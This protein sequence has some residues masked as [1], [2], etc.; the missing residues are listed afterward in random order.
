MSDAYYY[1]GLTIEFDLPSR[2]LTIEGRQIDD[3]ELASLFDLAAPPDTKGLMIRRFAEDKIEN[4]PSLKIRNAAQMSQIAILKE[5]VA[6]WNDWR[7]AHPEVRPLLYGSNLTQAALGVALDGVDFAN[8]VLIGADLRGQRMRRANFHEANLGAA[9]LHGADLTEGN[10]C[11]AD[12]YETTLVQAILTNANLQGA[13]LAKTNLDGAHLVGCKVYGMAAW[14]LKL[15]SNT[16]QRDLSIRYR[17]AG[18]PDSAEQEVKV[19]DV[20]LAQAV[21]LVLNNTKLTS[22]INAMTSRAVLI[23]GRFSADRKLVLDAIRAELRRLN[24]VPMLF[25]FQGPETRDLIETVGTLAHLAR[26]VIADITDARS[27][28]QELQRIVPNLPS[29][30]VQPIIAESH[31]QYPLFESLLQYPW[32]LPPHRYGN[33]SNLISSLVDSVIAPAIAKADEVAQRR[34]LIAEAMRT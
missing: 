29:L 5:G 21:Y 1:A 14:D 3:D 22:F 18:S 2:R 26:F 34:R 16:E 25:D 24:Y 6:V 32:V 28:P 30:P 23:L 27:V 31:Y 10:F 4:S 13:Q 33:V 20:E 19:D 7:S 11:R 17:P 8:A 9:N 12:L 15:S